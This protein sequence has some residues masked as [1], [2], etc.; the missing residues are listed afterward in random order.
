ST[1]TGQGLKA[2][3][4]AMAELV[5]ARRAAEPPPKARIVLRPRPVGSAADFAVQRE[6]DI[7]RVRG[8]KPERWVRQTD[9]ANAEAVGYLADRLARLG[10]E[11]ALFEAG[12]VAGCEVVIGD[13]T[14]GVV[15]DWE[16]TL[17]A[18]PGV[19]APPRGRALR[20]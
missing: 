16:P 9:F 15:F 13:D 2:L 12:A 18:G 19:L 11:E 20:L 4:F 14:T 10:V 1:K 3:T 6:G 8:E 17:V 7:W 5:A